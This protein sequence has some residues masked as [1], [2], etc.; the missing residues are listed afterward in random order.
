MSCA[1]TEFDTFDA[2]MDTILKA[3]PSQVKAAMKADK[4]NRATAKRRL[5]PQEEALKMVEQ[6]TASA[7][8]RAK[9][10]PNAQVRY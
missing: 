9:R 1:S 7:N 10:E 8:E 2:A 4:E 6:T 3:D 5:S